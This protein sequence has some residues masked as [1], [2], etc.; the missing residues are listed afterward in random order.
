MSFIEKVVLAVV[1]A[2]LIDRHD[3]RMVECGDCFG[4]VSEPAQFDVVREDAGLNHL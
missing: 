1:L 4:L 2:D 3:S